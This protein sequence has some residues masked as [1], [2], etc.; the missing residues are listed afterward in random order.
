[1]D[2]DEKMQ[3]E[4]I[5]RRHAERI[6]ARDEREALK[7]AMVAEAKAK[8]EAAGYVLL[9]RQ[10][11][12]S[13]KEEVQRASLSIRDMQDTIAEQEEEIILLARAKTRLNEMLNIISS[14]VVKVYSD[15]KHMSELADDEE[16]ACVISTPL[17]FFR[18][19]A[20]LAAELNP[21]LSD[22]ATP[23]EGTTLDDNPFQ[24]DRHDG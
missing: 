17:S 1:M 3:D 19:V 12:E 21:A 7:Q 5:R 13:L 9:A 24:W 23:P 10:D 14:P 22:V 15:L 20:G 8:M 11:F 18:G 2:H 16:Q 4:E 6:L